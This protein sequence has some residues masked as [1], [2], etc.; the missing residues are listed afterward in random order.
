MFMEKHQQDLEKMLLHFH[1]TWVVLVYINIAVCIPL[2]MDV[3]IPCFKNSSA[4][5]NF[6][7]FLNFNNVFFSSSIDVIAKEHF[8]TYS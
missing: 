6:L 1:W 5:F 4:I 2:F 7:N 3:D 8:F